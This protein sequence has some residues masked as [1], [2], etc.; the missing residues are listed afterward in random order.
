MTLGDHQREKDGVRNKSSDPAAQQLNIVKVE[1]PTNSMLHSV[2]AAGTD[3]ANDQWSREV[4]A[5][6]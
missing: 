5:Y 3:Q 4:P 1:T 2:T 6:L